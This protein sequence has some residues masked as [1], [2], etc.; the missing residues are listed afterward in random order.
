MEVNSTILG[1]QF[2]SNHSGSLFYIA[3]ICVAV[4]LAYYT[5]KLYHATSKYA[6]LVESQNQMMSENR[7][8]GLL[9]KKYNR[10]LDEMNNLVAHLYASRNNQNIFA[11]IKIISNVGTVNGKVNPASYENYIFWENIEKNMY[12]NQSSELK[13]RLDEYLNSLTYKSDPK[14]MQPIIE[15]LVETIERRHLELTKQILEIE[16]DL[17]ISGFSQQASNPSN[18]KA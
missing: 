4:V 8:H 1:E 17:K 12:L 6:N 10:M 7:D 9:V 15:N 14:K 11:P 5:K 13:D 16:N 2:F 18:E 3:Q